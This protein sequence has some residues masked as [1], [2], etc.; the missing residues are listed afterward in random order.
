M[1]IG[2]YNPCWYDAIA[3]WLETLWNTYG[4]VACESAEGFIETVERKVFSPKYDGDY[5]HK[6]IKDMVGQKRLHETLTNVIIPSFDIKLLQPVIFSTL[7]VYIS[8]QIICS[9]SN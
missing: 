5:L 4:V 7:K 8:V 9:L 2:R 6:K 1:I 3:K